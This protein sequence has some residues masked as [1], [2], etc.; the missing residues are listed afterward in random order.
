MAAEEARRPPAR[1]SQPIEFGSSHGAAAHHTFLIRSVRS[2]VPV[3]PL[4]GGARGGRSLPSSSR[5]ILGRGGAK[6]GGFIGY[7]AKVSNS[8]I[9]Q[10][11]KAH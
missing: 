8:A 7:L 3:E 4:A 5:G 9:F 10:H 1:G 6:K 2:G 11:T